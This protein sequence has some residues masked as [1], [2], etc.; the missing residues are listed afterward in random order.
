MT[1]QADRP[2]AILAGATGLVGRAVLRHLLQDRNTGIVHALT[3]RAAEDFPQASR[4]LVH[5]VDYARPL[6]L[7]LAYECYIALGTTIK[8]AGS[9]EAF[10]A[11]DLDAVVHVARAAKAAG[12]ARLALVSSLGA[13]TDSGV[14]YNRIKGEAEAAVL[15]LDFERLVVARPSLLLGDRQALGQRRRTGERLAATLSRPLQPWIPLNWRPIEDAVVA[16]ALV[17]SLRA[18]GPRVQVLESAELAR[19][20]V[21]RTDGSAQ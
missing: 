16:R 6:T 13:R 8:D 15:D 14:F 11:V 3:R 17:R 12:V 2:S 4:L 1:V 18:D 5:Q 21:L 9:A 7:P 20:G 19:V 10:R